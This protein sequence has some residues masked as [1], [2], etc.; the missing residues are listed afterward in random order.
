LVERAR[1]LGVPVDVLPFPPA[2]AR[3][4]D[5]GTG[6]DLVSTVRLL[7]RCAAATAAT[8]IYWRRLRTLLRR[9]APA[10]IHSNGLK[11]HVLAAWAKPRGTPVIWHF[12]DFAARRSL[13]SRLLKRSVSRCSAI[14]TNSTS[15]AEDARQVCGDALPV[16]PVWNAVDL[17]RFSPDGPRAD[18]DVLAELPPADDNVVR[19]GLVATFARWKG[20]ETFLQA[21]S[22]LPA[23]VPIR[24]YVIGGPIY[25]T[26]GSQVGLHELR[27]RAQSLGLGSRVGFTGFVPDASSAIRSLDIVVHASTEPEPFGLVIAEAMACGRPVVASR[28]GGAIELT[29]ACE[30]AVT[31]SP[32]DARGLANRIEQLATDAALRARLGASGRV[33]AERCLTR[34]RMALELTPIYQGLARAH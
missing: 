31:H 1:K 19:V 23:A 25:E 33:T 26:S 30:N 2:L 7:T 11:M 15:V 16:H 18:L 24:G 17:R 9:H 13:T 6:A 4:G 34:T 32:G 20:H 5:W 22:L 3:L 14:I 29:E 8:F 12:H 21:L 27:Q 10:V 28:A